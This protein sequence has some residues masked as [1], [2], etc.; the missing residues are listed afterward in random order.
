MRSPVAA[1]DASSLLAVPAGVHELSCN[2]LRVNSL[3]EVSGDLVGSV[4]SRM[5]P[6]WLL[7]LRKLDRRRRYV[8]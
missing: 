1:V 8:Y 6:A 5:R 3:P 4:T 2:S 7:R